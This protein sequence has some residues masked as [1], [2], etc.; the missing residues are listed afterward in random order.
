[1]PTTQRDIRATERY[2]RRTTSLTLRARRR[3]AAIWAATANTDDEQAFITPALLA[4]AAIGSA[5]H[6]LTLGYLGLLLD[7]APEVAD[8]DIE[9]ELRHP[10]IGVYRD[11][12]RGALFDQAM[13]TGKERAETLAQ[14]RVI[15]TQRAT[16][17]VADEATP[18]IVGWRRVPQGSTCRWC[19]T[20][21]TQRY[22]TAQSASFGHGHGGTDY[23]DC[24]VVPI[25]GDRDPGRVINRPVLK[26]VKADKDAAYFDADGETPTATD[27]PDAPAHAE[28]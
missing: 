13:T 24:D 1:M 15:R 17:E 7:E 16:L 3:L 27:R 10:F 5:A 19:M 23:C 2:R 28:A 11:L 14:E 25:I 12:G 21:S 4:L 6:D 8:V 22:R 9:Q 18:Q 20:V 26:A